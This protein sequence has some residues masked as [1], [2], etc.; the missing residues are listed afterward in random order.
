MLERYFSAPKTLKRLRTGPSAPYID[1][2]AQSLQEQGYA[3]ASAVRYLR[4]AAHL[5][6]FLEGRG[7]RFTDVYAEISESFRQ[8]L[9]S[10]RC[11]LSNGGTI[12]HHI[13]FGVKRF[14][15]YLLQLGVCPRKPPPAAASSEPSSIT[16]FCHWLEV[17]RGA[18]QPTIRQYCR[19]ATEL[20]NA[21][22]DDP[23]R[24]DVH[25]IRAFFLGCAD[26]GG[27]AATAE[28]R[29]TAVRA[30]L[31]YLIT[32]GQCPADLDS[33]VPTQ[34]HWRLASLP[35]CLTSAQIERLIAACEGD[36][37]N[38]HRDRA[39]IL[40]LV[41]DVPYLKSRYSYNYQ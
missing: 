14:H 28:K 19:G 33:A 30:F 37:C 12:S 8:H 3:A 11:P 27:G 32:Q 10:C 40:L 5:G 35:Q 20:L 2:F 36:S 41:P 34:A 9:P 4:A 16:G 25:Q 17:H 7:M 39:M 26:R 24:W 29:V 23:G 18:A 15:Q 31:R 1:G 6:H 13:I 22:G 21:L 38:R